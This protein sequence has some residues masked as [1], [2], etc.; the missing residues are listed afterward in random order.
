MTRWGW[1]LWLMVAPVSA[2]SAPDVQIRQVLTAQATAWNQG[3]IP[4]FMQGYE[5]SPTTTFVGTMVTR[6]YQQ[7]LERYLKRYPTREG[8]GQLTFGELTIQPLG[9]DYASVL[10]RWD[11]ER[12]T[13]AGGNVGG[14]FTL[15]LR[16]TAEGW[17]IIQ[18]H[19]S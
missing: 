3:D 1:V 13:T 17:K 2:Q 4:G 15:L 12:T 11:L 19:T 18:D 14:Y 6:G 5:A 9:A 16:R 10:G 7:V 8:M